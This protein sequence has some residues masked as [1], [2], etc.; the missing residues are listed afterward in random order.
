VGQR[1]AVGALWRKQAAGAA[2]RSGGGGSA[3]KIEAEDG[4]A[5]AVGVGED[6]G[7]V[8]P[9]Q[10]WRSSTEAVDAISALAHKARI[11][12]PEGYVLLKDI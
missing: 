3:N 7:A 9:L 8:S 5:D 11:S 6:S 2:G 12:T 1:R 10:R 4:G